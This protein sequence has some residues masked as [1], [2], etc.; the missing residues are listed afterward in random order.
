MSVQMNTLTRILVKA[1][2]LFVVVNLIFAVGNPM[3]LLGKLSVYNGLVPGRQRLS[4][5]YR[6]DRDYNLVTHHFDALFAAH[7][8]ARPKAS[9]EFRVLLIG[10]SATWGYLLPPQHTL[11]AT[12]NQQQLRSKDGRKLRV[13]NLGYPD[14]SL[15]K[16]ALILQRA[17]AYQ[18]DLVL[19]LVTLNSLPLDRQSEHV[20]VRRNPDAVSKLIAAAP[21]A[22]IRSVD[23]TAP[24]FERPTWWERTLVGQRRD[25]ADLLRLQLL[26]VMWA[27]TGVDQDFPDANE[28]YSRDLEA[29]DGMRG[30]SA[31]S[32]G[33]KTLSEA[34]L[35]LDL[36]AAGHAIAKQA[37]VP[38]VLVN[39]PIAVTNGKNSDRRYNSFYPRWA[40]D[41]YRGLMSALTQR[42]GWRYL[43][44]W[45]TLPP[46]E[47]TNTPVH[48][49][50]RGENILAQQLLPLLQGD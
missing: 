45:N 27:V 3:P 36:L 24:N 17:L 7:E 31:A 28:R 20:L 14:F 37:N 21:P 38:L 11:A 34:D 35:A 49:T 48:R 30:L 6:P 29:D 18:P 22:S 5:G 1:L 33:S 44:A 12:L 39:E 50:P 8:I 47:F 43:D 9:D 13:Y 10:D 46:D 4:F 26:G 16:D 41:Q 23:P 32:I 19:W 2:L 40:Y 15:T 42:N 25:L